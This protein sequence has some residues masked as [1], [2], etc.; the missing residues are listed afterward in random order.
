MRQFSM[1]GRPRRLRVSLLF[2][3][4]CLEA[5]RVSSAQPAMPPQCQFAAPLV[6][7]AELPEASGIAIS[8][9]SPGRLWAHNDS[10]EPAL[11]ALD[12]QG[13]VSARIRLTGITVDDWEAVAVGACPEGSCV[14]IADIGDNEANRKHIT[15]HRVAEPFAG[16]SVPIDETFHATYPDGAHDA[17][18]LLVA[19]DGRLFIVTK[20]ETGA[21]GLY[22][23]PQEL[24]AGTTHQ[25]ERVGKPRESGKVS[26]NERI[27]DGAVSVDGMWVVLR[28]RQGLAFHRAADLLAGN[29]REAGRVDVK[30]AGEPQG[31]GVAIAADGTVYLAG[32]GGGKSQPGTFARLA[33]STNARV[34]R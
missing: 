17:E 8:R 31:E 1:D 3:T 12:T 14:Y 11:V 27:T 33:C 10:G 9:R 21:V 2:A 28:T 30:G 20:G 26:D 18:T 5:S 29:W 15:I 34:Q 13:S 32:E 22:R 23:F 19:P 6:R 24:R 4:L 16:N 7:I 25:L